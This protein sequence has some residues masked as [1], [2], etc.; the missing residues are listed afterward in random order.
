MLAVVAVIKLGQGLAIELDL[1]NRDAG[2]SEPVDDG[3]NAADV[4]AGGAQVDQARGWVR[5]RASESKEHTE[6]R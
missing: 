2:G 1:G 5:I 4:R 6:K 3:N